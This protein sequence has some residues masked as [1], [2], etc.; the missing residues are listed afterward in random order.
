M[1]SPNKLKHLLTGLGL[2]E[3]EATVF[4]SLTKLGSAPASTV[5]KDT[6]V[7]RTHVYD[8][9][10]IL[11]KRGLITETEVR[12]VKR[13]EATDHAGLMAHLSR[14]QQE[15]RLLEKQLAQA[16]SMFAGLRTH[17]EQRTKVRFFEGFEGIRSLYEELRNDLKTQVDPV[18]LIT[19]WPVES[20][21]R[22]YPQ[23]YEQEVYFNL[24][25]LTK[26]DIMYECEMAK[27]YIERYK[28][29]PA[30][31]DYRIWPKE[32]KEFDTDTL[33]WL[34]KVAFTDVRGN[35]SGVVI[36][37]VSFARTFR[38]WFDEMWQHLPKEI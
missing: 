30:K 3:K 21:E 28:K 18:D 5:A 33:C 20:L 27:R 34:N 23:F 29:G 2:D 32:K 16:A 22:A 36:E 31:H 14:K 15:M 4:L 19:I 7:T 8:L 10:E 35:P 1:E 13:Y 25:N 17:E 11:K 9:V 6:G 24:P 12:G 26:R 38:M 37:N